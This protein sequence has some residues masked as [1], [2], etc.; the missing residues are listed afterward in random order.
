MFVCLSSVVT[1]SLCRH[2]W[3]EARVEQSGQALGAERGMLPR[4]DMSSVDRGLQLTGESNPQ[5]ITGE[6]LNS[7]ETCSSGG[8]TQAVNYLAD[9]SRRRLEVLKQQM[10][11]A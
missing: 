11:V 1:Q 10:G 2:K 4:A 6:A 3:Q 8:A 7:N 5:L 9:R